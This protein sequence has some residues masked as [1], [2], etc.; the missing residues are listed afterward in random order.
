MY[1]TKSSSFFHQKTDFERNIILE[2]PPLFE[3]IDSGILA[4]YQL[5]IMISNTAVN[6]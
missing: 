3:T 4:R 6:V 5:I 1:F 2:N